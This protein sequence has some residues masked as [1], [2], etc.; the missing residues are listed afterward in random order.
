MSD[1]VTWS[2]AVNNMRSSVLIV[3]WKLHEFAAIWWIFINF[4]RFFTEFRSLNAILNQILMNFHQFM[5]FWM[6]FWW[7]LIISEFISIFLTECRH[8]LEM[9][10]NFWWIFADLFTEFRDFYAIFDDSDWILPF[11]WI[12]KDILMISDHFFKG[13]YRILRFSGNFLT[14]LTNSFRF[15]LFRVAAESAVIVDASQMSE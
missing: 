11:L 8:F 12:S 2:T 15:E 4:C 3:R 14:S 7:I 1:F 9:L 13:S 6:Q 5:Q 10:M